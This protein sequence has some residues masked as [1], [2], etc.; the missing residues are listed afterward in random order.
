MCLHIPPW[1]P[2]TYDFVVLTSLIH[3]RKT[4]LVVLQIGNRKSQRLIRTPTYSLKQTNCGVFC[5]LLGRLQR[6][7][8]PG[9]QVHLPPT[10]RGVLA[11]RAVTTRLSSKTKPSGV[12]SGPGML[13]PF[14]V[15]LC[16]MDVVLYLGQKH[17]NCI[18]DLPGFPRHRK[19]YCM[20]PVI[21]WMF[22]GFPAI[23]MIGPWTGLNHSCARKPAPGL[24]PEPNECSRTIVLSRI[25]GVCTVDGARIRYWIY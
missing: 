7:A 24:Y 25:R 4:V 20:C 21:S 23:E 13:C 1:A 2:H 18:L 22:L 15:T 10:G 19:V 16:V 5:Y 12:V 17:F 6:G 14:Q 9:P 3:P 8:L 11:P